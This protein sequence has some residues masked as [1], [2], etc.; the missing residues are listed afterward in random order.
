MNKISTLIL[1]AL[2]A[3]VVYAD[4]KELTT[5]ELHFSKERIQ[6]L[7]DEQ[8]RIQG[9]HLNIRLKKNMKYSAKMACLHR[10]VV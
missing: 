7:I 10:T 2:L 4:G 6:Q 8:K 5:Q 9:F 1:C 3:D